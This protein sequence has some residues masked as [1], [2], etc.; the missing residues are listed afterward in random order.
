M[1]IGVQS[2]IL[3]NRLTAYDL[4][5]TGASGNI[6]YYV[7]GL[8]N[9]VNFSGNTITVTNSASLGEHPIRIR[10]VDEVGQQV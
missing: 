6:K 5:C 3:D 7:T 8:P 1:N 2:R 9:G 10:A 4:S